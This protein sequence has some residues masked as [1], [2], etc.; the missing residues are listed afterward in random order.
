MLRALAWM[1]IGA[2]L[3]GGGFFWWQRQKI[4]KGDTPEAIRARAE[5]L[6]PVELERKIVAYKQAI[7][8]RSAELEE[9]TAPLRGVDYQ[10]LA[11]EKKEA[12]AQK[13]D[14]CRLALERLKANLSAYEDALRTKKS[15]QE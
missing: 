5:R 12:I 11:A 2:L 15:S 10:K 7:E 9:L 13:A 4:V 1:L 14:E 8:K 3:A 6:D